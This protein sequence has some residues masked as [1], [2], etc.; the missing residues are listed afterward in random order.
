MRSFIIAAALVTTHVSVIAD[1][2]S[3]AFIDIYTSICLKH[4]NNLDALRNKLENL[5]KLPPEKAKPFLSLGDG[6]AWPVP[7]K[8]GLFV[9]AIPNSKNACTVFA[10]R[11]NSI[12]AEKRFTEIVSTAPLPF[13]SSKKM[14]EIKQNEKNGTE[15]RLA[16]EW[17]LGKE[18][19]KLIFMLSTATAETA[20][21]QGMATV[22]IGT[23]D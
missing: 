10:R 19:R 3:D 5:P 21:L 4:L 2:A 20:D 18:P 1:P 14:E 16:Y 22:S 7:D 11:L 17:G 23:S 13:Q 12:D 15:T 6:S 8:N 9:L